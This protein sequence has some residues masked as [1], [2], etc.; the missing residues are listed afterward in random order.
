MSFTRRASSALLAVSLIALIAAA[1]AP[2]YVYTGAT[3]PHR[4]L[5]L[6]ADSSGRIVR[7][8]FAWLEKC[9]QAR[10]S[11]TQARPDLRRSR[12]LPG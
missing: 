5:S 12:H 8:H 10:A 11:F 2:A 3:T 6:T 9:S 4:S 1:S 7:L